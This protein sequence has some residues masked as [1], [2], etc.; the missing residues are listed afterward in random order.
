MNY[1]QSK[2]DFGFVLIVSLFDKKLKKTI[3]LHKKRF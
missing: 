3:F 1:I 2:P